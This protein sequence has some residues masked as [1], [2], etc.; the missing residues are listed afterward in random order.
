MTYQALFPGTPTT[1][2]RVISCANLFIILFGTSA[3]GEIACA[4]PEGRDAFGWIGGHLGG[5]TSDWCNLSRTIR[6]P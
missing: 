4:K 5:W 6:L 1:N 2:F 3:H